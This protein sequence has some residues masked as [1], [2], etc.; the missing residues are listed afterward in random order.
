M[1]VVGDRN[2]PISDDKSDIV[3]VESISVSPVMSASLLSDK[4]TF[5]V[6][7]LS[8]QYQNISERGYTEWAWNI[9]PLKGGNNLL[10]LNVIIPL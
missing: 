4:G 10:K 5:R 9:I 8:T 3:S 7:T 2:I 1:L 6:D